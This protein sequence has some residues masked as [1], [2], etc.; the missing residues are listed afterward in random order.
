MTAAGDFLWRR[1]VV[2]GGEERV[3]VDETCLEIHEKRSVGREGRVGD[4]DFSEAAS[5]LS[6]RLDG[7]ARV[8]YGVSLIVRVLEG[9][10]APGSFIV[11]L[12]LRALLLE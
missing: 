2:E 9:A 11:V 6:F 4:G 5:A 1:K 3:K 12:E 10:Y 7:R 8:G